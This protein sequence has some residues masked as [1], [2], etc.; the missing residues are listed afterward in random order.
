MLAQPVA[1]ALDLHDDGMVEQ[2]VKQR[3]GDDRIAKDVT[4]FGE[5]AI[6]REDHRAAFV[7][8]GD[9]LEEQITAAGHDRQVADLVD[10]QQRGPGKE[11]DAFMQSTFALGAGKLTEQ[12]GQCAEID[13]AACL[14]R[15]DTERDRQV[16]FSRAWRPQEVDDFVACDEAELGQRQDPIAI[17]RGLEGE[18]EP[19]E[20]FD[21]G[22]AT[23]AQRRLDAAVLAQRQ[24]L[25]EQDVDRLQG[26]NLGVLQAADD[27][28]EG[29]QRARHLEPDEIVANAVKHG[30]HQLGE[31]IHGRFSRASR[32][33]TAS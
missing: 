24:F 17:E 13:A 14:H 11:P 33:P 26:V 25:G 21:G 19:G 28:I 3:R 27:L 29:L 22:E 12:I 7:A 10:D 2:A 30:R 16:A 8:C 6:G 4:P 1:G 23:H 5:A 32:R 15:L 9:E 20:R 31:R 18:V